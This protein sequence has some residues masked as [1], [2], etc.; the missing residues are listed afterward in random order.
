[1][2]TVSTHPI[3]INHCDLG[4]SL[5]GDAAAS[6]A[7]ALR[8]LAGNPGATNRAV[9][10]AISRPIGS[11]GVPCRAA[12]DTLGIA[13][14]QGASYATIE[15]TDRYKTGCMALG[16]TPQ[17]GTVF[18][19]THDAAAVVCTRTDVDPMQD[20]RRIVRQLREAMAPLNIEYIE[21]PIDGDV[22]VTRTVRTTST[23]HL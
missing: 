23:T 8:V 17:A 7:K 5:T 6:Y 11:V 14:G 3:D 20:V 9:A 1:M 19:K 16:V 13:D 10:A 4:T 18:A 22:V 15:D 12:R 2:N 21:V